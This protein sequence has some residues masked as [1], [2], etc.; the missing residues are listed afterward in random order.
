MHLT[1]FLYILHTVVSF[2]FVFCFFWVFSLFPCFLYIPVCHSLLSY[3]PDPN[4]TL[5]NS[6]C[7]QF[8]IWRVQ[9]EFW[10][11]FLWQSLKLSISVFGDLYCCQIDVSGLSCPSLAKNVSIPF[12]LHSCVY[13]DKEKDYKTP[14][15]LY[16]FLPSSFLIKKILLRKLWT[17]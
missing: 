5:H 11:P 1:H 6:G 15:H 12:Q 10:K 8:L 13:I 14:K 17:F 16:S 2:L 3:G 9:K 7:Q 4:L